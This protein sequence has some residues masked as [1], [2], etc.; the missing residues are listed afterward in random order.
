MFSIWKDL[1]SESQ[2]QFITMSLGPL[3][4]QTKC[5]DLLHWERGLAFIS[6]LWVLCWPLWQRCYWTG[7]VLGLVHHCPSHCVILQSGYCGRLRMSFSVFIVKSNLPQTK[8]GRKIWLVNILI[9]SSRVVSPSPDRIYLLVRPILC[10]KMPRKVFLTHLCRNWFLYILVT[11][12]ASL[13]VA[14][15]LAA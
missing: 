13:T 3:F 4:R 7:C 5:W 8:R 11:D 6:W 9:T 15:N 10:R 1:D 14:I 2:S 12:P